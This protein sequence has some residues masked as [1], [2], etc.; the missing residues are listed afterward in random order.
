MRYAIRLFFLIPA[1]LPAQR[2][3]EFEAAVETG[4]VVPMRDG[5][6]L[7]TDIYRPARAGS[8]A[9]GRFP[10]VIYRTPYNKDGQKAAGTF[11]ARHGYVVLVQDVRG[12]FASEGDF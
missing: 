6:K 1:L 8:P 9:E 3:P 2:P 12:R 5:V 7:A 4:V 11:L 10:A